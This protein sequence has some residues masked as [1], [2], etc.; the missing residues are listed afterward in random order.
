MPIQ[1]AAYLFVAMLF[2]AIVHSLTAGSGLKNILAKILGEAAAAGWYRVTYNL[3]S[4]FTLIPVGVLLFW[5]PD[6]GLYQVGVPFNSILRVLQVLSI[7]GAAVSLVSTDLWRFAGLSQALGHLSGNPI[8]SSSENLTVT[9][10]YR[11]VRHP[12]YLFSLGFLWFS[13]RLTWNGLFCN[14]AATLYFVIGS[15]VEEKRLEKQFGAVYRDYRKSIPWLLPIRFP[16]GQSRKADDQ[17]S[18]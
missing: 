4:A 11:L 16:A 9:G 5:L 8:D 18:M 14:V 17:G 13:P 3:I 15:V 1:N 6:E 12:L 10:M 7:G 2:F